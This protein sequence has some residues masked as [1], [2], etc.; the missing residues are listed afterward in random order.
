[1]AIDPVKGMENG[2]IVMMITIVVVVENIGGII[3][4]EEAVTVTSLTLRSLKTPYLSAAER[5]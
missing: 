3:E 5:Q 4:A 2:I 1:M